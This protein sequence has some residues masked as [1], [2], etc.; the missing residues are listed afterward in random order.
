MTRLLLICLIP[1]IAPI[2]S[3][4]ESTH[5]VK[6]LKIQVLSTMLVADSQSAGEWGFAAVVDVDGKRILFDTGAHTDTVLKNA[7]KLGIDLSSAT[8]VVLTHHH[9]DHTSGLV[10]L[11]KAMMARNPNALSKVHAGA[12]IFLTGV[13]SRDQSMSALGQRSAYLA[14]GGTF[15][16]HDKAFELMPGVWLTGPVPRKYP[17][18]NWSGSARMSSATGPVGDLV[19]DTVPEDLSIVFDTGSGLV[20]LSGCGHA[21]VVNTA[22]YATQ[23][24]RKAPLH[25]AIGGFHL[26][27]LDDEKLNW[28]ADK[29]KGF[30]LENFLGAHCTGI[31][32][33]YRVRERAGLTRK[34]CSVA[35]VGATFELGKS[36][37]PGVL[38]E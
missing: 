25:A 6:E 28:T 31:E 16:E 27:A 32:A 17:E 37:K 14:T 29:L 36:M 30:G 9:A 13:G 21:G 23:I 1:L 11:R 7:E 33:T 10:T 5:R 2:T 22:E 12:G 26:F 35:A 3:D 4:A 15:L 38:S 24:V 18:R 34:T 8:D 19:E 20:L